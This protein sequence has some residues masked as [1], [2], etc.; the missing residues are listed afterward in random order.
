LEHV[1]ELS[2][3]QQ[4]IATAE[5]LFRRHGYHATS[6]RVLVEESGTPW[7]SIHHHF[8]GGK[9]ELG[10][11]AIELGSEQAAAFV[12]G[13]FARTETASAAVRLWFEKVAEALER[14]GWELGCPIATVALETVSSSPTLAQASE[15]AFARTQGALVAELTAG[16]V[17]PDRARELATLIFSTF[18]GALILARVNR[19]REPLLLAGAQ[20]ESLVADALR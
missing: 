19:S 17:E 9:E 6:W 11:A 2:T 13:S 14:S 15:R 7:G 5:R 3:R 4:M 20:F 18:E 10:V 12:A 8:P 16:G 1:N